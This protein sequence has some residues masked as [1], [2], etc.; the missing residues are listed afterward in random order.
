VSGPFTVT[1]KQVLLNGE[2]YADARSDLAAGVIATALNQLAPA[3]EPAIRCICAKDD[4]SVDCQ[5]HGF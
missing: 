1:G 2:H 5:V 3:S 4:W